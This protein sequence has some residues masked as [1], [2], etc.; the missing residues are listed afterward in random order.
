MARISETDRRA[1]D[2]RLAACVE[3]A[4]RGD[5]AAFERF[6][7]QTTGAAQALARRFMPG[8]ADVEDLLADAYFGAWRG[9][10]RFDAARGSALGWLLAIVR[11]RAIDALRQRAAHP[12]TDRDPDDE[13]AAEDTDPA[14][15]LWRAQAGSRLDE[16][17]RGLRPA[18]RWVL[19]LAYFR[20][21]SHS[22]IARTTGLP[23]GTVK[24]AILRAQ[25]RLRAVLAG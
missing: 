14:D 12:G 23:L 13:A 16:A 10:A 25:A 11:S 17:L 7:D 8:R 15:R 9:A 22:E 2:A 3:A 21:L 5:A 24:T 20:A 4:A 6:Y 1:R 19:A 18:E